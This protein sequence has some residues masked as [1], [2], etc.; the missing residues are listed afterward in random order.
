M[1]ATRWQGMLDDPLVMP[2]V[3][4]DLHGSAPDQCRVALLLIDVI[5]ELDFPE[6]EQMLPV[7]VEMAE[8]L[9]GLARRARAA[10]VPVIYVN[11]NF[12]RWRS[13]FAGQ[14]QHC[15][16][17]GVRGRPVVEKLKPRQTDY[18]I[19]KPKHSGFYESPLGLLLRSLGVTEVILTGIAGNLCVLYTANDA[20]MRDLKLYV[21]ADGTVSN[22][23]EENE[24]A[25]ALMKRTLKA[26]LRP[27]AKLD[28]VKM[29]GA[30][31]RRSS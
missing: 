20:Y 10:R 8:R 7:A 18:S 29:R 25:L 19:L 15:L 13:D 31:R 17:R 12:G 2:N 23:Q 4:S 30:P 21:P 3:H 9:A 5:N 16:R 14:V 27:T 26:D 11:D 24:A 6:A 22:T 1:W 28:L